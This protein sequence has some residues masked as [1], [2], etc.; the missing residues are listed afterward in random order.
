MS[1]D[2]SWRAVLGGVLL[3]EFSESCRVFFFSSNEDRVSG[4][5]DT[6]RLQ[7]VVRTLCC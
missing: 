5:A 1:F 2:C 4:R 3:V 7:G 6:T